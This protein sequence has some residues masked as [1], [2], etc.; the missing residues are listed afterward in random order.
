MNLKRRHLNE[1]QRAMVSSKV[2]NLAVGRPPGNSA[3]LQNISQEKAAVM[4]NVSPRSVADAKKVQEKATPEVI[5]EDDGPGGGCQ[6]SRQ[7]KNMGVY[8]GVSVNFS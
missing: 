7:Q 4:L 8:L 1:S 3:N 2:A 6:N 5:R